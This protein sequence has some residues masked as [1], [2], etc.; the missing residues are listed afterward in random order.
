MSPRVK[1]GRG[2]G[3]RRNAGLC[4]RCG[5][6]ASETQAY[7][8]SFIRRLAEGHGA[9]AEYTRVLG[10]LWSYGDPFPSAARLEHDPWCGK[11]QVVVDQASKQRSK[12]RR[13]KALRRAGQRDRYYRRSASG[14]CPRCYRERDTDE[15][16]AKIGNRPGFLCRKPQGEGRSVGGT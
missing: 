11:C 12:T 1:S 8:R 3:G 4:L 2:L 7:T 10:R 15:P 6:A 5:E 14:I 13:Q 9:D 16:L